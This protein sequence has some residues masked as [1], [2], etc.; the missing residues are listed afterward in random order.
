MANLDSILK[1][2]KD[3]C[4][5]GP[6]CNCNDCREYDGREMQEDIFFA[7]QAEKAKEDSRYK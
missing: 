2:N 1:T 7:E 3:F 4:T 6:D 5:L